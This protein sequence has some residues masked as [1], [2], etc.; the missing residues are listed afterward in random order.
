[1]DKKESIFSNNINFENVNGVKTVEGFD[2]YTRIKNRRFGFDVKLLLIYL[3]ILALLI[4]SACMFASSIYTAYSEETSNLENDSDS[5]FTKIKA[6]YQSNNCIKVQPIDSTVSEIYEIPVGLKIIELDNTNPSL[7]G[8]RVGDIIISCCGKNVY[9][10][11]DLYKND[12]LL[13]SEDHWLSYEI[14]RNGLYKT[15]SPFEE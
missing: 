6:P 7:N 13:I 12:T 1:M 8:L 3:L 4:T 9:D 5:A 15:V 10:I 14:F 11:H 2:E